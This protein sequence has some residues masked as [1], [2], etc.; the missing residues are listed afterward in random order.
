M[1]QNAGEDSS[2]NRG[3]GGRI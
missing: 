1:T 2:A 3:G